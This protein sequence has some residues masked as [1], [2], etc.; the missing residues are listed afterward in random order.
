VAGEPV[1]FEAR[2]T[3]DD[4]LCRPV[5]DDTGDLRSLIPETFGPDLQEGFHSPALR[6]VKLA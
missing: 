2:L 6:R 3:L 1:D 4:G 5:G